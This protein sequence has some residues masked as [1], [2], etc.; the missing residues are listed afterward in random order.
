M[1]KKI[2]GINIVPIKTHGQTKHQST[3]MV[4]TKSLR[5]EKGKKA[6]ERKKMWD[7]AQK[8]PT[9]AEEEFKL[10]FHQ[11]LIY[12][13]REGWIIGAAVKIGPDEKKAFLIPTEG[14][15]N[16][17]EIQFEKE[18][19]CA[20]LKETHHDP[21]GRIPVYYVCALE[22][23]AKKE[24][25]YVKIESVVAPPV[26]H[27]ENPKTPP[28]IKVTVVK[29]EM[30]FQNAEIATIFLKSLQAHTCPE[31]TQHLSTNEQNQIKNESKLQSLS[32]IQVG[33]MLICLFPARIEETVCKD[34]QLCLE[35]FF[36][37]IDID[38]ML[39]ETVT[40]PITKATIIIA[41]TGQKK[42]KRRK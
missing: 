28:T 24:E 10:T 15:I 18:Y 13:G 2:P 3:A 27:P 25:T 16:R 32:W 34:Y 29:T 41:K 14:W 30:V 9:T 4:A 22:D 23:T 37:K 11:E 19:R 20:I 38:K 8:I 31:R 1:K 36:N 26:T 21:Y 40:A 35:R 12:L 5:E 7:S 42:T 39:A 6:K 17:K 33:N